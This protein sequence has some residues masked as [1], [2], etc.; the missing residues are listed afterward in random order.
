MSKFKLSIKFKPSC[1]G[2]EEGAFFLRKTQTLC[3][4]KAVQLTS[5]GKKRWGM[6]PPA[7]HSMAYIVIHRTALVE[8]AVSQLESRQK[9]VPILHQNILSLLEPTY[10]HRSCQL[11]PSHR[12]TIFFNPRER[13]FAGGF[14]TPMTEVSLVACWLIKSKIHVL[15]K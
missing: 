7:Q 5:D 10:R 15:M 9:Q 13:S 2:R 12:D 3:L 4:V 11:S 6:V 1:M 14:F 8:S